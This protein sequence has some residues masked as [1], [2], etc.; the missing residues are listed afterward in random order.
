MRSRS[1][2]GSSIASGTG[3]ARR[4][5]VPR[6]GESV[7]NAWIKIGAD[8]VVLVQVP[9]QEMGQGV[10]TALPMLVAE[11]LDCDL[12]QVRFEQAPI[13]AVYA[14]GTMLADAVPFRPDDRGWPADLA[15]LTQYRVGS[16]LA[17][18]PP[19]DRRVFA[20]RGT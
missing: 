11:E 8:G 17:S 20:M 16:C 3:C 13:D 7:F 19:A 4:L 1:P 14:N 10:T 18:R 9:R 2:G 6:E 5:L 15:R 12:A